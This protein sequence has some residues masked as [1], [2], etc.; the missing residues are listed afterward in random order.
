[1]LK[2]P[3]VCIATGHGDEWEAFCLD[4]DLAV[5]GRSFEEVKRDLRQ[6]IEMYVEAA[7][8][9]PEPARSQLLSREAPFFVRLMWACRLFIV[10]ISRRAN[11]DTAFPIEFPV[12]CPA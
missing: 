11:R 5:Q 9:E 12:T 10:I 4:F 3:L 8:A 1:M 6:A 2:Q 7:L